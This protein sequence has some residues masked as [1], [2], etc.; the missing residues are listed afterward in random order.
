M[1]PNWDKQIDTSCRQSYRT[2]QLC[3]RTDELKTK[4]RTTFIEVRDTITHQVILCGYTLFVITVS[5]RSN[6]L[7]PSILTSGQSIEPGLGCHCP[8]HVDGIHDLMD[9]ASHWLQPFCHWS[10]TVCLQSVFTKTNLVLTHRVVR[11]SKNGNSVE[12][13]RSTKTSHE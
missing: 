2:V 13:S 1:S 6:W 8:V 4:H 12:K 5:E 7:W 10:I 3:A 9:F 11:S